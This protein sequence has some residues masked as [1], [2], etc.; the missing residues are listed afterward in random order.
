MQLLDESSYADILYESADF[1]ISGMDVFVMVCKYNPFR[2]TRPFWSI[3]SKLSRH[4]RSILRRLTQTTF[5]LRFVPSRY[6]PS[7]KLGRGKPNAKTVM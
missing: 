1:K 6:F 2:F 5:T 3:W 7:L 4:L